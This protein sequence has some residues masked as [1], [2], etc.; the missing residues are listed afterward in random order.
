MIMVHITGVVTT[1]VQMSSSFDIHI[2]LLH[3]KYEIDFS[4][5][6]FCL[7]KNY[8]AWLS[9]SFFPSN[10]HPEPVVR[11]KQTIFFLFTIL[12]RITPPH[13]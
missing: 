5:A 7:C 12:F 3:Q 1:I 6:I 8:V 4:L 2:P 9:S 13:W 10:L 11:H